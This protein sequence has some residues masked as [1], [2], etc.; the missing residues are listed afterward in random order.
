MVET[1][2]AL[3]YLFNKIFFLMRE[4]AGLRGN[5]V[6]VRRFKILAW[7][8]G[9]IGIPFVTYM[10][11]HSRDW[12]FGWLELGSTPSMALGLGLALSQKTRTVPKWADQIVYLA[13]VVGIAW[14]AYDLGTL[15]SI[16][17][18]LELTAVVTF[19]VGSYQLAKDDRNGYLFYVLMFAVTG[20]LLYR[21]QHYLFTVQQ[22]VSAI[23]I[24]TAYLLAGSRKH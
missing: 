11:L 14:S 7:S 22:I 9:L 19:F 21:Q 23:I 13:I 8:S 1:I 18:G 6:L 5:A 20:T 15:L 17:Q 3:F 24:L 12:I 10:L 2:G 16:N 4:I